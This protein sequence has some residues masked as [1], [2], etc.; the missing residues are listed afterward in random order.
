MHL[1]VEPSIVYILEKK[2]SRSSV[3][4]KSNFPRDIFYSNFQFVC[5]I[6]NKSAPSIIKIAQMTSSQTEN[7]A[8]TP[9]KTKN[10]QPNSSEGSTNNTINSYIYQCGQETSEHGFPRCKQLG[11]TQGKLIYP[12]L[13]NEYCLFRIY[14]THTLYTHA[15]ALPNAP[16]AMV[17]R[18]S[19][20]P[21][22]NILEI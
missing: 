10:T 4:R 20:D 3:Y 6:H 12:T 2:T 11:W 19:K 15:R 18:A 8:R 16:C 14:C 22:G 13:N 5:L 21:S 9:S 7:S 1:V 17:Q